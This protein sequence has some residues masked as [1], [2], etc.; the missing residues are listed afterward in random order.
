[1]ECAAFFLQLTFFSEKKKI[2]MR[3]WKNNIQVRIYSKYHGFF[4]KNEN[5]LV[6]PPPGPRL[7]TILLSFI[8]IPLKMDERFLII[9]DCNLHVSSTHSRFIHKFSRQ[10]YA[11]FYWLICSEKRI[12]CKH[13]EVF[14][15]K[16]GQASDSMTHSCRSSGSSQLLMK[17]LAQ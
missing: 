8:R 4:V 12:G 9:L 15:D 13:F 5:N 11:T 7:A 6:S 10:V 2:T 1:M 3:L 16:H 14:F 17:A